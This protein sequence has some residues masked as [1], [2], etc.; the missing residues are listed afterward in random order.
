LSAALNRYPKVQPAR[1][2]FTVAVT[3]PTTASTTDELID[4][5]FAIRNGDRHGPER[6]SA[7]CRRT[8]IEYAAR[9]GSSEPEGVADLTIVEVLGRIERLELRDSPQ[10]WGYLFAVARFRLLEEQRERQRS[11]ALPLL[12]PLV[13][14]SAADVEQS[15]VER[16]VIDEM[17]DRL[18]PEQAEI[19]TLRFLDDLSISQTAQKTGRSVSAVKA[20]Q[21]RALRM[22]ASLLAVA[23]V[24]AVGYLALTR[25]QDQT[26]TVRTSEP[27]DR[28]VDRSVPAPQRGTSTDDRAVMDVGDREP[29]ATSNEAGGSEP[30]VEDFRVDIEESGTLHSSVRLGGSDAAEPEAGLTAEPG[31]TAE[32]GLASE[33]ELTAESGR[34]G[35]ASPVAELGDEVNPGAELGGSPADQSVGQPAPTAHPMAGIEVDQLADPDPE[36]D[37]AP[38]GADFDGDG[39]LDSD[40]WDDD[41]DGLPDAAEEA[42]GTDPFNPDSDGDGLQDGT[43][44]GIPVAHSHSRGGTMTFIPDVD[45]STQTDP[46]NPDSDSDGLCDG[47]N[48]VPGVCVGGEDIDN[49]GLVE[50]SIEP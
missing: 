39:R 18:T 41:N 9:R 33:P 4:L 21:R 47:S 36:P 34:A 43:E 27:V 13:D 30:D 17:L 19:L 28:P 16:M 35:G 3:L 26:S 50:E 22:S 7:A 24:L 46:A 20:L 5:V 29:T 2:V 32:S 38:D 11:E 6:F 45:S 48:S 8:L 10:V 12:S 40:D 14:N 1:R 23:V 42:L 15:I 37:V 25:A 31:L 44:F 49:D